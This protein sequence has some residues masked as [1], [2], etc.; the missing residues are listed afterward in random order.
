MQKIA[1]FAMA[2]FLFGFTGVAYA[3]VSD[4]DTDGI[5]D[6]EDPDVIMTD[7]QRLEAGTYQ[8]T[9][10]TVATGATLFIEGAP[11]S[12]STFKGVKLMAENLVVENGAAINANWAGYRSFLVSPSKPTGEGGYGHGGKG[13]DYGADSFGGGTYGSAWY[14]KELGS[15]RDTSNAGGG[16]VW[17]EAAQFQNDGIVSANG[18]GSRSSGGSILVDVDVLSGTGSFHANGT[19]CGNWP[20]G[21]SGGGGRVALHY[22]ESTFSGSAEAIRGGGGGF[23]PC[24][25]NR[26]GENGT[27]VLFNKLDSR[28]VIHSRFELEASGSPY[29]FAEI[30]VGSGGNLSSEEGVEI[31]ADQITV[32]DGGS[33]NTEG[34]EMLTA[35]RIV[36]DTNAQFMTG[37][38]QTVHTEIFSVR[39]GGTAELGR[40]DEFVVDTVE[41]TAGGVIQV[42]PRHV[43]TL[44]VQTLHVDETSHISADGAGYQGGE[45]PGYSDTNAGSSHGGL[46]EAAGGV[47]AL[48][49]GNERTPTTFGSGGVPGEYDDGARGGGA[50]RIDVAETLLLDGKISA[51][52]Y[53]LNVNG[54]SGGSVYI[55]AHILQGTGS[56]TAKGGNSRAP[57]TF[58]G[59]GGGGRVAV[60]YDES[61]FTGL[62][63]AEEG[64][65]Y[66]G[67]A[68]Q[69]WYYAQP[70]TVVFEDL[71]SSATFSPSEEPGYQ[72]D[73]ISSGVDPNKGVAGVDELTFKIVFTSADNNPPDTIH[74]KVWDNS[75]PETII[76]LLMSTD[77]NAISSQH[78]DGDYTNGEQYIATAQFPKG[79]YRYYFEVEK[80]TGEIERFPSE[81]EE[82]SFTT[83]FSSIAFFPGIQSSNLYEGNNTVWLPNRGSGGGTSAEAD[84]LKMTFTDDGESERSI[85]TKDE[86]IINTAYVL[87]E[88]YDGF[89]QFMDTL[90][91]DDT[92]NAWKPIA[93][94]W[95]LGYDELIQRGVLNDDET[96]SYLTEPSDGDAPYII[97]E[98]L[99]LAST[100]DSG[101]VTIITHSNGGL[102]AK[103]LLA[104]IESPDHPYHSLY[105]K[106][107]S[108]ILVAVPQLGTPKAMGAM[109]HGQGHP[110][111]GFAGG[112]IAGFSSNIDAA[113]RETA[114]NM[115][116]AFNLLPSKTYTELMEGNSIA[117]VIEFDESLSGLRETLTA[118]DNGYVGGGIESV[119]DYRNGVSGTV[120]LDE[121]DEINEFLTGTEGRLQPSYRNVEY[122]AVLRASG[123]LGNGG[124][125][126]THA[127]IDSWVPKDV[128]GDDEP[129]IKV[130]QIAG[131]GV[132]TM[133]GIR[134]ELEEDKHHA[135]LPNRSVCGYFPGVRA[136]PLFT[137][138]GDETVVTQSA[139]PMSVETWYVD[140]EFYNSKEEQKKHGDSRNRTHANTMNATPVKEILIQAVKREPSTDVDYVADE[141]AGINNIR[142][143]I[144]SPVDMH[145]YD[146]DGNHTGLVVGSDGVPYFENTIPG[147][148]I[149]RFGESVYA[150]LSADEVYELAL[151]G[152]G[153]GTFTLEI[154]EVVN[155]E[156]VGSRMYKDIPVQSS[157][158][159]SMTVGT[160]E[161][162]GPLVFDYNGDGTSDFSL[163]SNNGVSPHEYLTMLRAVIRSLNTKKGTINMLLAYTKPID[164][165]LDIG[166]EPFMDSISAKLV[167]DHI[168]KL[169]MQ[170]DTLVRKKKITEQEAFAI[171]NTAQNLINT[172]K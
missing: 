140:L 63:T 118:I 158:A 99:K 61:T 81:T 56:I 116:M 20:Y 100:S 112:I 95:R 18:R 121:Y 153:N 59:A 136:V 75:S 149:M 90:E 120:V 21:G 148:T 97:A 15:G 19:Y 14:P 157:S 155:D 162:A 87:N 107:D 55:T 24:Q 29:E 36:V 130:I 138:Q 137:T 6:F 111:E 16:A 109:L 86:D 102:L 154:D 66:A 28:L 68:I 42:T 65:R 58:K 123:I 51:N 152:K 144:H 125:S 114:R 1:R 103:T 171:S 93:Y 145:F 9:N 32:E 74:V 50:I 60:Y 25:G 98:L 49:Y 40:E 54:A 79:Q 127:L 88:I 8:Y 80:Q 150:S 73:S 115:P 45:G 122:P 156:V 22:S 30:V 96:I 34:I 31:S 92:I 33:F 53:D 132:D 12:T 124:S 91:A 48:P 135:C 106:I 89:S 78:A 7:S 72:N 170:V 10:L 76:P 64:N 146:R 113:W 126:D 160:I 143:S 141:I 2:L 62:V 46:G 27:V 164:T 44:N 147:S 35:H 41:V 172:V 159:G 94:D 77:H 38:D 67:G 39:N 37:S 57:Y 163:S 82:L 117:G 5:P 104:R 17:I 3:A 85:V 161:E 108:L 84:I 142:V 52:A 110:F 166:N 133:R 139:V 101:K 26:S 4:L 128:N 134:Y 71:G 105:G 165:F 47:A 23:I 151:D 131:W 13:G 70:G 43:L 167:S 168:K 11:E 83:G 69:Q 129:D 169:L 119:K